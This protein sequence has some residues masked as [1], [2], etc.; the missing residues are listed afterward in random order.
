MK[1]TK[2]FLESKGACAGHVALFAKEWPEGVEVALDSCLR[3][4]QIGLDFGWAAENLLSAGGRKEYLAKRAPLGAEWRAKR[5]PL[6][7]ECRAKRD[8][9]DAEGEAKLALIDAECRAKRAVLFYEIFAKEN[10]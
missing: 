2:E 5:A 8:V 1:I 10:T 6:N 9:V 3:A 7:A 4:A